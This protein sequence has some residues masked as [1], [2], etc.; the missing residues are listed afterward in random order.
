MSKKDANVEV[1]NKLPPPSQ[2]THRSSRGLEAVIENVSQGILCLDYEGV[3]TLCNPAAEMILR[4]TKNALIKESFFTHF[5]D[6]LFGFSM[7]ESLKQKIPM[8]SKRANLFGTT[9]DRDQAIESDINF[10]PTEMIISFRDISYTLYMEAL[11]SKNT[12]TKE[13]QGMAAMMAHEVRNPLGGM[14]G[15]ASL[16]LRDLADQPKLLR[17]ATHVADGI[18]DLEQIVNDILDHYHHLHLKKNDLVK[19]VDE[20]VSHL[21]ADVNVPQNISLNSIAH[22]PVIMTLVDP[23]ALRSAL[24]NLCSNSIQAMPEG[25]TVLLE[26]SNKDGKGVI[27]ISDTGDG[28]SKENM[29]KLF[30]PFFTTRA[31]GHGLGL[32]EVHEVVHAHH[33][34]IEVTSDV[35]KGTTFTISIPLYKK[36]AL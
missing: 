22:E 16:L 18:N 10:T 24:L 5:N 11:T 1:T 20:L 19:L 3:I 33:G 15:F 29:L 34:Q 7:Q 2:A 4:K 27:S 36:G 30:T 14:K 35:G 17:L 13:L 12:R 9:I 28:I 6:Q 23:A 25:G 32:S 8:H 31:K 26:V 21:K